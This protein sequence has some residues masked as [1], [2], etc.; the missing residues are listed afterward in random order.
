MLLYI[1]KEKEVKKMTNLKTYIID[2]PRYCMNHK[3]VEAYADAPIPGTNGMWAD[4]CKDCYDAY[5]CNTGTLL[6][7]DTPETTLC[8][9]CDT[10]IIY[11]QK[12]PRL[13]RYHSST[14]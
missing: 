12:G 3:T 2:T 6:V 5:D 9:G 11:T 4:I 1:H 7:L 10:V 8:D 13:C 14:R